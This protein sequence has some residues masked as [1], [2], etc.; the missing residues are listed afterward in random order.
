MEEIQ[1]FLEG[2]YHFFQAATG[3]LGFAIYLYTFLATVGAYRL[4][5]VGGRVGWWMMSKGII[6][7]TVSLLRYLRQRR[8]DRQQARLE[9]MMDMMRNV[10]RS[11]MYDELGGGIPS[12]HT[13]TTVP[14]VLQL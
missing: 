6:S 11:T 12:S 9:A 13:T 7:P 8:L 10:A 4:A 14:P 5:V 1:T 2:N 3:A